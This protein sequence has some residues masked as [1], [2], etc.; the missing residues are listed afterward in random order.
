M[1][2]VGIDP[3]PKKGLHVFDERH[4]HIPVDGSRAYITDLG[5]VRDILVCWDA[6]LRPATQDAQNTAG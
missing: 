5:S 3:A 2:I 4:H 1:K 6:P